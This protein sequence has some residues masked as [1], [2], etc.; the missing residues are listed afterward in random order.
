M[1]RKAAQVYAG[2]LTIGGQRMTVPFVAD[3][4]HCDGKVLGSQTP[5]GAQGWR[6]DWSPRSGDF[7][8]NWWDR[9]L[10]HGGNRN[11]S[12]QYYGANIVVGGTQDLFWQIET[13]FPGQ[14]RRPSRS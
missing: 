12:L 14:V 5:D 8:V 9:R 13:H 11:R 7:H 4:R 6:I 1:A 2:L 3:N 10:D